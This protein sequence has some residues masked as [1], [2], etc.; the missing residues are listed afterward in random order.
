VDSGDI[1]TSTPDNGSGAA[2]IS[3]ALAAGAYFIRV[4]STNGGTNYTLSLHA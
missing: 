3:K 4:H 1:I 2:S